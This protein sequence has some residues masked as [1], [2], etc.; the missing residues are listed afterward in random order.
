MVV[1][2]VEALEDLVYLRILL[3]LRNRL[4]TPLHRSNPLLNRL[5]AKPV[6]IQER[7]EIKSIIIRAILLRVV[8]SLGQYCDDKLEGNM[9][10]DTYRKGS[11]SSFYG[12]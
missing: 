1:I 6:G 7:S 4:P 10:Q 8:C 5:K 2:V 3:P 12:G 9:A 11:G